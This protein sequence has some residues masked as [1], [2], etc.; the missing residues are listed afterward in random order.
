MPPPCR[1]NERL[2]SVCSVVGYADEFFS[3][4]VSPF[5]QAAPATGCAARPAPRAENPAAG[6]ADL[7][8]RVLRQLDALVHAQ[9]QRGHPVLQVDRADRTDGHVGNH[10][11]AV[12]VDRQRVRHLHIDGV[13]PGPA[14][15]TARNR[16]VGDAPPPTRAQHHR[17]DQQ[18]Q[19]LPG[20]AADHRRLSAGHFGLLIAAARSLARLLT[21]SAAARAAAP[22]PGAGRGHR[23]GRRRDRTWG[24]VR[25]RRRR[26]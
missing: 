2:A 8:D 15:R 21:L 5:L 10:H 3:G 18:H 14:A 24:D 9:R 11:L 22:A 26:P 20:A 1:I 19:R 6:L 4:M 17:D 13:G 7:G 23:R 12:A 16:D 25:P